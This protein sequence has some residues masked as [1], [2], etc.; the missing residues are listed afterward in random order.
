MPDT[1]LE[2]PAA[3]AERLE[4]DQQP[5]QLT[6]VQPNETERRIGARGMIGLAAWFGLAC[7]LLEVLAQVICT[8]FGVH[9]RLYQMSRH[10]V[11]LIP[12][13][14]LLIF[15]LLGVVAAALV[16]VWPRGGR[17][18]GVRALAATAMVPPLLVAGPEIYTLAWFAL[19]W[20]VT[21]RL[22]PLLKSRANGLRRLVTYTFPGFVGI[23]LILAGGVFGADWFKQMRENGRPLPPTGSPNV[24]LL[25]L[26]TVRADHVSAYG[27]AR[28][29]TPMLEHLAARGVRFDNA[30]TTAPWTLPAHASLFTGRLPR[31]MNVRFVSPV[32]IAYPTLAGYLGSRGYATA[33]F[34]G[35]VLYCSYETGLA[36]GFT[37]YEDYRLQKLD[38]FF[39]SKL[40]DRG[41]V[42][43]FVLS[44]WVRS[45][46]K[47]DAL[48][49]V[50]EFVRN[51]IVQPDNAIP[52]RRKDAGI[53][54]REFLAWL[55]QRS[56]PDRPFF[57]FLNYFDAHTPYFPPPPRDRHFGL[58]PTLPGDDDVL[59]NWEE[60]DKLALHPRL[61]V[62]ARDAYDDCIRAIDDQLQ[63]LF[64]SLAQRRLL[65]NTIVIVT[66]DHGEGFGEHDLYLH[67]GSLFLPEVHVPL[68][69]MTPR[70]QPAQGVVK[71]PV[72]LI[73]IPATIIDLAG[74]SRGSPIPGTPLAGTW[75][76][77]QTGSPVV[78]ELAENHSAD[79]NQGRT[80]A[81][82]GPLSSLEHAPY[83]YIHRLGNEKEE[84]Y[85]ISTDPAETHDLAGE[86]SMKPVLERL[87]AELASILAP[88]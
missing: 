3:D 21:L 15:L 31:E 44:Y 40:A 23:V 68:I 53:V 65:D 41:L 19:T 27:Y 84:L 46:F 33:G 71:E 25:V 49:P 50:E 61:R 80:P 26:D 8:A 85:D 75:T 12:V 76:K 20:G 54:N 24:L 66:S 73:D 4:P 78:S 29:T 72:S 30:R 9:G 69:V 79:P 74:L 35:N 1:Q 83:R 58:S 16:R 2:R 7:G 43:F 37:H 60:I 47:S 77:H 18:L 28:P 62:L 59:L 48:A 70:S 56:E 81:A 11:W 63:P 17:W 82:L 87:R 32:K 14:N 13:A 45:Q 64:S 10:F 6:A 52:R 5:P 38:G 34:V 86:S 88:H 67:A 57:A 42:G 55:S 51:Y 36:E 39:L 22:A